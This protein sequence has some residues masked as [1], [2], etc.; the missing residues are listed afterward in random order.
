MTKVSDREKAALLVLDEQPEDICIYTRTIARE[1]NLDFQQAK[2]SVRALVRK[3]LAELV[4]GL[5]TDEGYLAGS[6][7]R[8]TPQG[9]E[10]AADIRALKTKE[11]DHG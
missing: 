10:L 4:R 9:N 5:M 6:G 2:R 11:V 3:G 1:A 8:L 7:Y